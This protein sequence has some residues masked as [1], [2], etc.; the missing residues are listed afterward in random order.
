MKCVSLLIVAGLVSHLANSAQSQVVCSHPGPLDWHPQPRTVQVK[1]T[2]TESLCLD[3]AQCWAVQDQ[4]A[5]RT[6]ADGFPQLCP[7]ELQRGD[8][9]LV[10]TDVTLE[11]YGL[12]LLNVSED[13]FRRCSSPSKGGAL[14]TDNLTGRKRVEPRWLAPGIH[15]FMAVHEGNPELCKL[16]LRL[17]VTV[18]ENLCQSSPL[19]RLC[20]GSGA[21]RTGPGEDAYRCRCHLNHTGTFCEKFDACLN[22]PCVNK[23][24]CLSQASTDPGHQAYICL[25]PPNFTGVNCSEVIGQETC[26]RVCQNGTCLNVSSNTFRCSCNTGYSGPPCEKMRGCDHDPCRNGGRCTESAGGFS[27]VCPEGF[28]GLD[29]DTPFH[30]PCVTYGCPSERTCSA[31][32][33][34]PGC[35]CPD[36]PSGAQ[37][38][39]QSGPCSLSPCLNNGSCVALGDDYACRCLPGFSGTSC[40]SVID[41]CSLLS[42][43]CLHEGVCL[44]VIGGY[45]C[46][47]SPGWTG[48]F[49]QY[50]DDAC[51]I[52]PDRCLHG[53]ACLTTSQPD[54][55]PQY[56]CIC[57]HGYTGR[58]CENDVDECESSPCQHNGTCT[59][60]LGSYTCRCPPGFLGTSCEVDVDACLLPNASC[61]ADAR[62]LDLPDGLKHTCR[63]PCPS[64]IQPCANEG[65]CVLS[66]GSSYTCVCAPG[67]AGRNC[68][69]NVNDCVRHRCQNGATC[70]DGVHGYSCLCPGGFRGAFC[71]DDVDACVGHSCSPH[72]VCVNHRYN[73]T[74]RCAP[75]FRGPL[76]DQEVDEC[77]TSP[78]ANGATCVG[79]A[80]N[81]LCVCPPGFEGRFCSENVNPCS[82]WP[83]LNGGSCRNLL[84]DYMCQCPFGFEGKDC[85]EDVDLC[86]LEICQEHTL[87]CTETWDGQ[88]VTCIC[89]KGFGGPFCEVNLDDCESSPCLN[90]A[91]CVDGV[92]LYQCFCPEGFGGMNCEINYDECDQGFCANN[93]T[94]IDQVAGYE[95]VCPSGFADEN[96]STPVA[97]CAPGDDVC[98]NGG[99]CY[100]FGGE[101][102]CACPPGRTGQHCEGNTDRCETKPCGPLSICRDSLHGYTCFCAPG[103]IGRRCEMEVDECLSVPCQNGGTCSDQLDAFTCTC[104]HGVSGD[105][106]EINVDECLSSPCLHSG[107]CVDQ[108]NRYQC[109][110]LP[111]FTGSSC[112]W[113]TDECASSPCRNGASCI[114][115]PGRYHCQCV[116]PFKVVDGFYCLCNPGYAGVACE[117]DIDDCVNNMCSNN[118]TCL[119]LHLRYRCVC[120]PGWEGEF[121]HVETDE[122]SALPCLNNATCIDLL[123]GYKC[124]CPV[125]WTGEDCGEDVEECAS[126]PCLNGALCVE[127]PE[128]GLFSCSC[129]PLYTGPRCAQPLDPCHPRLQPCLHGSTCQAHPDGHASCSCPAGFEGTRCEIDTDECSSSPCLNQGL[130]LDGLNSYS[131]DCKPGFSGLDCEDDINECASSPCMNNA[132]C[133]DLQNRFLCSCPPEYFGRLCDLDVNEC[134]S[135]PCLHQG[136]C[137]NT[138]GGFDCVCHPGFTGRWCERNVDECASAPCQNG[139]RCVDGPGLYHCVCPDGFLGPHCETDMDDCVSR[140]CLHGSCRDGVSSYVCECEPGWAGPRCDADVDECGSGPCLHGGSC[141]DLLDKYACFCLDGYRGRRCEEDVDICVEA[142]GDASPCFNGA[143]C[144]DGEGSNFTCSCPAGYMG[145]FC[146]VNIQECCSDPCLNGAI[147]QDLLDGYLCHCRPGWTGLRCQDDVNECL[148]RPCIQGLCLQNQP[149]AGFTCFCRP[150]YVGRNC[151]HNYDDCLLDPCPEGFSCVDGI[152]QARCLPRVPD[153]PSTPDLT[154]PPWGYTPTP[155][156]LPSAEGAPPPGSGLLQYTGSSYLAFE[157]LQVGAENSLVVRFHT[158]LRQGTLL[159]VDQ[160]SSRD[161]FFMKLFLLDGMLQYAFACSPEEGVR[162]V[163]TSIR[164]DDGLAHVVYVRQGLA[165]CEAE[166]TVSGYQGVRSRQSNYWSGLALQRTSHLFIGG[167]PHRYQPYQG[168]EPFHNYTGCIEII[169]INKL[170]GFYAS[171]AIAGSNVENCRSGFLTNTSDTSKWRPVE[172]STQPVHLPAPRPPQPPQPT[173]PPGTPNQTVWTVST[174]TQRPPGCHGNLCLNGGTCWEPAGGPLPVRCDCPL[175]FTGRLCE[176]DAAIFLPFF[177][178]SSYLEVPPPSSLLQRPRAPGYGLPVGRDGGSCVLEIAVENRTVGRQEDVLS[179]PG[180]EASFGPMFL[181]GVPS[182]WELRDHAQDVR[183]L[184]GCLRDLQV[185]SREVDLV[186]EASGGRNIQNCDPPVCQHL[187]CRN[188]GT[189]VSDGEGWFCAC[190][191]LYTGRLCQ[192]TACERSPCGRGATCLPKSPLEAVCLCPYGRQGLLCEE[193]INITR[194]R[195]GGN[196]EFGSTSFMAFSPIPSLSAFYEFQLK[197]TF[198]NNASAWKDNLILFSGQK[199]EGVDGDDFLV[200][201]VRNGRVLHKFSLGSGVGN[202]ISDRLDRRVDIHTVTFGRWRRTGWLKVDGQRNRTGSSPGPLVGL[203]VLN[204]IFVGGYNEHTPE[205]L[206]V[207]SRFRNGFQGCVFDLRF[208]TRREGA[209]RTLGGLEGRPAFG[210]SVGQCGVTPC[211][212][213]TCQNGGI[214]VDSGSSVYCQCPPAWKGALCS[215]TVSVCDAEH[216]PPPLCAPGSTCIPLPRGYTCQCPLGAAGLYCQQVVAISDPYFSG[217][218]S[219]WMSFLGPN[220]RHRTALQLQFQTLS[221]EGVLFYTAQHLAARSG[222]FLCLSLASGFLQLRYNLGDGTVVLQAPQRVDTSGR[223]WHSARAGRDGQHGFLVLDGSE[224]PPTIA[225]PAAM[226]TLD[227]A[228]EMFVGGV[229]SLSA[230]ANEAVEAGSVGFTGGIR[231]VVV[232]GVELELTEAGALGGANVGDWDGTACGYKVCRNGGRCRPLGG[233]SFLCA[234]PPAWTGPLCNQSVSCLNHMCHNGALCVP[235]ALPPSYLCLCPLGRQGEHCKEEVALTSLRFIGRSY[236]KHSDPKFSARNLRLTRLAFNF[237]A[238]A[239]D[240]LMAWMGRAEHE[241]DDYLAVGLQ[242]GQLKVAVNLGERLWPPQAV[243]GAALCCGRWHAVSLELSGTVLEVRLDGDRV[244]LQD[245][246]PFERYVAL[247]HG[248]VV[249]LGGFELHRDVAEVSGG[250][251]SRRFVGAL[252]DVHLYQEPRHLQFVQNSEGF[253]VFKGNE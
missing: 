116:A 228:P 168:A 171:N 162:H 132:V 247:N 90:Q 106:C 88:N 150:G 11:A 226:T 198:A 29:C 10:A 65:R 153:V 5:S 41:F 55:A 178:G 127:S 142:P 39:R 148:P 53:A 211:T 98:R 221:P 18:K 67:W 92:D 175:H 146:E 135:S 62:C 241:D 239:G 13:D 193:A 31:G 109:V 170:K 194:A 23:G 237:S 118:S 128:P 130:C 242:G 50:V 99:T 201:G 216:S 167:L 9:L 78:C 35:V 180:S 177:N 121:C 151:E 103:F 34:G 212:L 204:P 1:W 159:Y 224:A 61:P 218:L 101:P 40:E 236:V 117:Q 102:H 172:M 253:N 15:Y 63:R 190:P 32:E 140:P 119:D 134:E 91:V 74:C 58:H 30:D 8:T 122:C 72:G 114:D 231:E 95:C 49:C 7:L 214:C 222:D 6:P 76:C 84:D 51:R 22:T 182:R 97:A 52:F 144:V 164:V 181:G 71:E 56:R 107:S 46:L 75:G 79:R 166:V 126:G 200:L 104:P 213:V 187:P 155:P 3:Q 220:I 24:V 12:G 93:S 124:V 189:C 86:S 112:E 145:D 48:E 136:A 205:L 169:E 19:V 16:G 57:R 131:C 240:G 113:D 139:A 33:H 69:V 209:L 233:Q 158:S 186:G 165:P 73:H 137:I 105:Y 152:N 81:F 68:R 14:F 225:T 26:N 129:P 83:C 43:N 36:G 183:G 60:G 248:G 197:L 176:K 195:F 17:N 246:D 28:T 210:R 244:L 202:I 192:L 174:P 133:Q 66:D 243:G 156:P 110:C 191:L 217:N 85:S 115:Q 215:D 154:P 179:L 230:V 27:C 160:G 206:P 82:S 64:N 184:V 80:L 54:A 161:L 232:N 196:D 208:R 70:V 45:N 250:L 147:C 25:C 89:E 219:S 141:V 100:S 249:Y 123:H 143:T 245:V 235:A 44:S 223:T 20:S 4:H 59:H 227:V 87:R 251:F 2:L 47:C 38:R 125:G 77:Q 37:C 149:G 238:G 138:P 108:A 157:G 185:N 199:G 234:C 203:N 163:N 111:G 188:G 21:C 207:G 94:C 252:K 42:I 120:L 229:S 173:S 96:C